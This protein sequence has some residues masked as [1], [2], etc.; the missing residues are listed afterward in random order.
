MIADTMRRM[1]ACV[2]LC[3]CLSAAAAGQERDSVAPPLM[4]WSSWNTYHVDISDSLIMRQADALVSTGLRDAGYTYINIDDGF[5]G[6]RDS[7]GRMHVHEERFP[8]GM[9][10]VA[11]HIHSLG[12][13]AGIYSDAGTNTCGSK[14]D[15]DPNGVGAGLYGHDSQDAALYFN[16]WGFD[17][18]KIDYCGA[19]DQGLPERG[20]YAAIRAAIDS[21]ARKDIKMN[22]CRWAFPGTWAADIACSWRISPDI[23]PRW[24][25]IKTIIEKNMYLSAYARGG[26]YNDMDMLEIG[27]GMTRREEETHFGVWCMMSSPLLIGCDLTSVPAASLALLKNRELI[28]LNQDPL[29]LQAYVT[30]REGDCCVLVKDIGKRRGTTRAVA[31]YNASDS[32]YTFRIDTRELELDGTVTVR[33][34]I[35]GEDM[36]DVHGECAYAVPPHGVLICLMDGARRIDPT[37]YEAEWAFLPCYDDLGGAGTVAYVP[38]AGCSGGMKVGHLGGEANSAVWNDVYSSTGGDYVMTVHYCSSSKKDLDV[39]V[40]GKKHVLTGLCSGAEDSTAAVSLHVALNEGYN[41]VRMG[42]SLG[43]APDIDMFTL[44]AVR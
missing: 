26:H 22:I 14:Y 27:R 4:G 34:I 32:A 1:A 24:S 3:V 31:F 25:S 42:N 8:R 19:K 30:W 40:N 7:T 38:S 35:K 12:L 37:R 29:G 33:D 18:I 28:A 17:F 21:I 5:F 13:R 10:A 6:Y 23:R 9:R 11:D 36:P 39:W 15:D 20:R 41:E 16:E 43:T 2:S 44:Q